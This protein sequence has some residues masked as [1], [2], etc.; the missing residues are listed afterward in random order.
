MLTNDNFF[1]GVTGT[2]EQWRFTPDSVNLAMMPTFHIA[3]AG[4]GMV[5]LYFGCRT[6]VLRDI[7][8]GVILRVIPEK[9]VTNA[10][11]VPVVIQFL[12]SEEHTSELQSLMRISYA[13]FCL[14]KNKI[15]KST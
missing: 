9:G 5:G 8:P 3:G 10:F 12:R 2:A 7:D 1:K 14:Q 4:W 15:Q 11:M 6:V 13:V